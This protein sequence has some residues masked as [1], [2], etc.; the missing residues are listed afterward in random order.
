MVEKVYKKNLSLEKLQDKFPIY[1]SPEEIP[2]KL[3][4]DEGKIV[5]EKLHRKVVL[6]V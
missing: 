4:P 1:F 5:P 3:F 2:G 6:K